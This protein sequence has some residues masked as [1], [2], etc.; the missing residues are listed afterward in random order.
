[1]ELLPVAAAVSAGTGGAIYVVKKL[2][3]PTLE[4]LGKGIGEK[5]KPNIDRILGK[6]AEKV[7]N[8]D[9][10]ASPNNRVARE[11]I[12]H[13]YVTDDE[14][15][16]EYFGGILA[17][18]RSEDGKDDSALPYVDA[19]KAMSAKQLHL[20]YVIYNSINRLLAASGKT[21][22]PGLE[23][24]LNAC[25]VVFG[26]PH[27]TAIG[28]DPGTDLAGLHRQGL[29][30]AF[31]IGPIPIAGDKSIVTVKVNPTTFGVLLFAAAT[32]RLDRWR[33]FGSPDFERPSN[34][35]MPALTAFTF[36]DLCAKAGLSPANPKP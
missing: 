35:P 20:H 17:A 24:D 1:M 34:I 16:A 8:P 26:L 14:V 12:W 36:D 19:I 5:L 9:D 4:L 10:G 25:E 21:I 11:V 2:F 28:L 15:A 7:D 3:D 29:V 31:S 13:G 32:N 23:N 18:S 33:A 27:L 30:S 6:A 22:N